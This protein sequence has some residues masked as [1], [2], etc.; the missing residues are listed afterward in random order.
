MLSSYCNPNEPIPR[1]IPSLKAHIFEYMYQYRNWSKFIDD[2][3]NLHGSIDDF[4]FAIT[5]F[6]HVHYM[7]MARV[8]MYGIEKFNQCCDSINNDDINLDCELIKNIQKHFQEYSGK[9]PQIYVYG[10]FCKNI[11]SSQLYD[12]INI[13]FHD[14]GCS[15]IFRQFCIPK[16]YTCRISELNWSKGNV[17]GIDY[18]L[19][20]KG[21]NNYTVHLFLTWCNDM[22]IVPD[23]IYFDVDSLCSTISHENIHFMSSLKSLY[24]DCNVDKIIQ[25][26]INNKFILLDNTKS[27]TITHPQPSVFSRNVHLKCINVNKEQHIKLLFLKMKSKGWKCLNET[28]ET[29]WCILQK[30]LLH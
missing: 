11:I 26:C 15:E 12:S 9:I 10:D 3:K 6:K 5:E 8:I 30:N 25:N 16:N 19:C 1:Q 24:T 22:N 14:Y 13:M 20:F 18:E 27:P 17:K 21:Y 4:E 29:P 2:I 23:N 28:C 7:N